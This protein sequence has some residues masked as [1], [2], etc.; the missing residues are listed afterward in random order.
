M[1]EKRVNINQTSSFEKDVDFKKIR[2]TEII[3]RSRRP[4]P[5]ERFHLTSRFL[6]SENN[7]TAAMLVSQTN[8]VGVEHFSYV[9][10]SFVPINLHG[11]WPG[12]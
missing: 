2:R 9:K 11:C 8:P 4:S 5:K 6:V 1:F 7:E 12:E 10:V 3:G